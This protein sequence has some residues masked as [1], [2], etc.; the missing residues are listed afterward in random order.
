MLD[1]EFPALITT[2]MVK[3]IFSL[4]FVGSKRKTLKLVT[5]FSTSASQIE[6]Y[7]QIS[8]EMSQEFFT[9]L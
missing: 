9:S 4:T 1:F 5:R 2:V 8:D 3:Y 6:E 7:I